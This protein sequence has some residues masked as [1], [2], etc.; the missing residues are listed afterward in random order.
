[1]K[2]RKIKYWLICILLAIFLIWG[3]ASSHKYEGGTESCDRGQYWSQ[4]AAICVPLPG[5]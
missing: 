1:M 3:C 2:T 5:P 4:T